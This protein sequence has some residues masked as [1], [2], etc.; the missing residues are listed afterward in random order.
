MKLLRLICLSLLVL[1]VQSAFAEEGQLLS[2]DT[3]N[4]IGYGAIMLALIV[5]IIAML[6]VLRAFK[7]LANKLVSP[8]VIIDLKAEKA[9]LKA[10]R[11]AERAARWQKLLSLKPMSE[12]GT[13]ILE[14]DYDGI[15]ELD[16]PTPGWFMVLFYFT[17]AFAVGY[18]LIYHVFKSA[19]L[20][21][22]EYKIEMADAAKA[23]SVYLAKSADKVNE[24]TVKLT[25]D[26]GVLANGKSIFTLRCAPCHGNYGQ[27]IVGPNLTD[28]YWLH[29]NKINDVFKTIKYGVQSKGMPTWESQLTPK[30]IAD[31]AN[32][33]KSIHG[34]NPANPKEPQGTKVADDDG[35]VKTA[36]IAK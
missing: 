27:G 32:Y 30:Q 33:V 9:A 34:S 24:N 29:G 6:A 12:E 17:I 36:M 15:K 19:P 18:L 13:L 25:T 3:M 11:K 7:I 1:G 16:N 22:D 10:E 2:G 23:K 31:V 21:Y 8:E 35:F 28:D 4:Y 5:F 26:P 20:Q 14:D